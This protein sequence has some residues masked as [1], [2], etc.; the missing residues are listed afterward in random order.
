MYKITRAHDMRVHS[1]L[2]VVIIKYSVWGSIDGVHPIIIIK[3]RKNPNSEG[4]KS[5]QVPVYLEFL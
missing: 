5:T 1:K 4:H 2:S 3:Y